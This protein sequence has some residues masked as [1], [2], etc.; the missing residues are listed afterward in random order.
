MPFALYF[1]FE[2]TAPTDNYFDPEQTKMFVVSY[3]LIVCFHPKLKI[4]QI[5]VERS[6]AHSINELTSID[7]LTIDQINFA[8]QKLVSQLRDVA[9]EVNG[10]Q[11]KNALAQMFT[12]A[13][14]FVKK[15]L[16]EWFNKKFKSQYL[17]IDIIIKNQYERKNPID[18]KNDK[19]VICKI[20]LKIDP[21]NHITPNNE[22]T[23]GAFFIRFE[24]KFL[25][26][27]YSFNELAQSEHICYKEN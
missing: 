9:L 6:Y 13:T 14:A 12:I 7:Y 8:D 10:R 16:M 22:M 27:I 17:E 18:W 2:T 11:C 4:P 1:D 15:I 23:Y 19:C 5:I 3:E 20:P 24:H 26:N 21:T 25:R